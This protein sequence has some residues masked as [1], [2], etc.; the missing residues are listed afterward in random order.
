MTKVATPLLHKP[1]S[2]GAQPSPMSILRPWTSLLR[3]QTEQ[4]REFDA[5]PPPFLAVGVYEM[6]DWGHSPIV[7]IAFFGQTRE[8]VGVAVT[9]NIKIQTAEEIFKRSGLKSQ[10]GIKRR[11]HV[12]RSLPK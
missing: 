1:S 8:P 10:K 12:R 2:T 6:P 9:V 4:T 7:D 5:A 3:S 11:A